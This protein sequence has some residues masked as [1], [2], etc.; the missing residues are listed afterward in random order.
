MST[1]KKASLFFPEAFGEGFIVDIDYKG[2]VI[3]LSTQKQST[4][5]WKPGY[6][7]PNSS[8]ET[9]YMYIYLSL[10]PSL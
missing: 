3:S 2:F 5:H 8:D 9:V 7:G 10:P 4:A 1:S 6:I